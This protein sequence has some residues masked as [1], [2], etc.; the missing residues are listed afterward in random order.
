MAIE[1]NPRSIRQILSFLPKH[2]VQ[3]SLNILR[4]MVTKPAP[5]LPYRPIKLSVY[6]TCRCNLNCKMCPYQ[7]ETSSYK[8]DP[9]GDMSLETFKEILA[10]FHEAAFLTI[11]AEGEPFLL[12]NICGMI[13]YA[14][15]VHKM[16]VRS[17]TNGVVIGDKIEEIVASGLA[18]LNISLDGVDPQKYGGMRGGDDKTFNTILANISTLVEKRNQAGSNLIL[19]V[20]HSITNKNYRDIPDIIDF[21][22]KLGVDRLFLHNI[23]AAD[24]EMSAPEVCLFDKPEVVTFLDEA[25]KNYAGKLDVRFPTPYSTSGPKKMCLE[26]FLGIGINGEGN[27]NLCC[28]VGT[29]RQ[30]GN[31][32]KE[33]DVWNNARFQKIRTQLLSKANPFPR[34][35]YCPAMYR[36]EI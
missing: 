28:T 7:N 30:Y 8:P 31:V 6:L 13:D 11:T 9:Y 2:T 17:S 10:R 16:A 20:S 21:T 24:T 23:V 1:N 32:F 22:E 18:E 35:D 33:K 34:C 26:P 4:Y 36:V 19:R 25:K 27:V 29:R 12:E 15:T 3:Q 5:V 14:S